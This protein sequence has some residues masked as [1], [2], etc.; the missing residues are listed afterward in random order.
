MSRVY[1]WNSLF[2]ACLPENPVHRAAILPGALSI[3]AGFT[4]TAMI[5]YAST[6]RQPA[7]SYT[8]SS[9]AIGLFASAL[10]RATDQAVKSAVRKRENFK[11]LHFYKEILSTLCYNI[12]S[13][14]VETGSQRGFSSGRRGGG[15]GFGE[16]PYSEYDD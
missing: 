2:S 13:K 12:I 11:V 15:G 7:L 3:A 4:A 8:V 6:T 5:F 10:F 16:R 9:F 1:I 14:I